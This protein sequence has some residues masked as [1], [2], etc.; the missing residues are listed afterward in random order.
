MVIQWNVLCIRDVR[1]ISSFI[2]QLFNKQDVTIRFGFNK[3]R[4][5]VE[6][7]LS[8]TEVDR[9]FVDVPGMNNLNIKNSNVWRN[10]QYRKPE[11]TNCVR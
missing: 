11:E 2:F 5:V 8:P 4:V 3:R 6:V 10:L 7:S 1:L 9:Q